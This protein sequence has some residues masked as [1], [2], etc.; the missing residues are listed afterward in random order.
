MKTIK[1]VIILFFSFLNYTNS[2]GYFIE[3]KAKVKDRIITNI[4]I[5]NEINYL[6]FLNPKLKNLEIK[7]VY[8]IA[9]DSL[10]TEIIKRNELENFID[11]E[12]RNNLVNIIE[13]KLYMKKNIKDK[14]EFKK[15][16]KDKNLDYEKIKEKLYIEAIWNQYIYDKYSKNLIIDK[17]ELKKKIN[18]QLKKTE[19][20]YE[21]NLSEIFFREE[22][23]I[24]NKNRISEIYKS[25]DNIGFENTANIYSISNT[26]K[27]G[28]LIGWINELQISKII[29]EN[30]N[31]LNI[32]DISEPIKIGNAYI[33]IKLNDKKELTNNIDINKE[34]EKL[35]NSERNRQLNNFSIIF[36][37]RL[38]KNIEINE[39]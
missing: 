17:D 28:G 3:I 24:D 14:N 11:F 2:Y 5:E 21:Y 22:I 37:K 12:E 34:L 35:I 18:N 7:K 23:D 4:D 10:I 20:K 36:Y 30:L 19:K 32:D 33:I 6:I 8:R 26:A 25:I 15:I 16:L 27:N 9:K 13:K 38:K 29:N 31:K 1:I 39:Y